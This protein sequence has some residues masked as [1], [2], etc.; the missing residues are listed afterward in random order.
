[1]TTFSVLFHSVLLD[2][3]GQITQFS[4]GLPRLGYTTFMAHA[5]GPNLSSSEP[6]GT[7]AVGDVLQSSHA[8]DL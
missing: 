5:R 2:E 8:V 4:A 1:M 6:V 3:L 7:A